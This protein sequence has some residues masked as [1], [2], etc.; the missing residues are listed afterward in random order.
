ML[1][2][3]GGERSMRIAGGKKANKQDP[4]PKTTAGI[5]A[6]R[7]PGASPKRRWKRELAV[8]CVPG[9]PAHGPAKWRPLGNILRL[10]VFDRAWPIDRHE[11]IETGG[12]RD[13]FPLTG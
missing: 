1:T 7:V 4:W 11:P 5:T 9:T 10:A 13:T 8:G 2:I 3:Q 12:W 6:R